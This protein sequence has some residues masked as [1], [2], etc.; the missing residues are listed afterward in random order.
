MPPGQGTQAS[1]PRLPAL[2]SGARRAAGCASAAPVC[3][4]LAGS[5]ASAAGLGLTGSGGAQHAVGLEEGVCKL[6]GGS[7]SR[8][9]WA[10]QPSVGSMS[11]GVILGRR[12][13]GAGDY[14]C[15]ASRLGVT[16]DSAWDFSPTR[17]ACSGRLSHEQLS[18]LVHS[19]F[20]EELAP[21]LPGVR[22]RT[23]LRWRADLCK[24]TGCRM[25]PCEGLE[26]LNSCPHLRVE[27]LR[28]NRAGP[29]RGASRGLQGRP[30]GEAPRPDRGAH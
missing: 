24:G 27:Q 25:T 22:F 30:S 16:N 5:V 6:H 12:R 11:C 17:G 1:W 28:Q 15:V 9:G 2:G 7:G 20:D 19:L 14:I 26:R 23:E 13:Q 10:Q 18:R 29:A 3:T 8:A 21:A 4:G